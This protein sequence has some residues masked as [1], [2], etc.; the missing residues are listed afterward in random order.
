M[1]SSKYPILVLWNFGYQ[2]NMN[3]KHCYSRVEARES[4]ERMTQKQAGNI[5]DKIIKAKAVH[6][7]FGGGEPLMRT[8]FLKIASRL[9]RAGLTIS[10]STNG[11]FLDRKMADKLAALKITTVGL[12]IYGTNAHT[13]DAFTRYPGAFDDLM[14]AL[15]HLK[16]AKVKS[17]FV[18]ILCAETVPEA[19]KV[20]NL[21]YKLGVN[22]VQF[23]TFKVAGNAIRQFKQLKLNPNKWQKVYETLFATA[24]SYPSLTIDF[25]LDNDPVI[26]RYL[27]KTAL[28]CPCGRYSIVIKPSGDVSACGLAVNVIGNVHRQSL[29]DI[30]QN[31]PELLLIRQETKSPCEFLLQI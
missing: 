30:W 27:G 1:N 9:T 4:R 3:C 19:A 21:A 10:L 7:H 17:K 26:A 14:K 31:S 2:C 20:I 23:Y 25:G 15:E 16:E 12:S 13:H 8:D 18:F 6:V 28:P 5:A 11:T 24:K 29:L 22:E